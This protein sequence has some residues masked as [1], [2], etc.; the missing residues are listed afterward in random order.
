MGIS[1]LLSSLFFQVKARLF[2]EWI[3]SLV[4]FADNVELD[5]HTFVTRGITGCNRG[6]LFTETKLLGCKV[7]REKSAEGR[8]RQADRQPND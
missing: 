8:D 3:P 5:V 4:L 7:Q 1:F 2:C 6:E